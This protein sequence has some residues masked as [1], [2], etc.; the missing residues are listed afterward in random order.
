MPATSLNLDNDAAFLRGIEYAD[1]ATVD[2]FIRAIKDM[3]NPVRY[4]NQDFD[5]R[6]TAR[7]ALAEI[8]KI[9][10]TPLRTLADIQSGRA[11]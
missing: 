1:A 10:N 11:A 8:R 7:A 3:K 5:R 2:Q 4:S 9:G 6:M